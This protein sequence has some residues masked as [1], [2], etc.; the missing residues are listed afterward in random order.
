MFSQELLES[1]RL[2]PHFFT[3]NRLLTFP[4]VLTFLLSGLQSA[5]QSERDRFWAA[6]VNRADS[7]R[8]VS[9]QAFCQARVK[10]STW[11]FAPINAQL[12]ALVEKHREVPRW[13]SLRGVAGDGRKVRLTLRD[14]GV[15]SLAEG[16][17]FGLYLPGIELFLDFVLHEP[18]CDERPMRFEAIDAGVLQSDDLLVRDRGFPSRWWVRMLTT[19]EIPFCIRCDRSAG[20]KAVRDFLASG[21]DEK[22]VSLRP[23]RARDAA[24]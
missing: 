16:V 3:R 21:L 19:R 7:V 15:R 5:V 1:S 9:A 14:K 11:A 8:E 18:L 13:R 12:I 22:V 17:A 6:L 4:T 2:K 20:F 24:Y 10:I 23:P